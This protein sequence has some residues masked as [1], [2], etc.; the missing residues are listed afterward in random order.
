M[1]F[2]LT[3]DDRDRFLRAFTPPFT[4]SAAAQAYEELRF[5]RVLREEPGR[6]LL[7]HGTGA[8]AELTRRGDT[9]VTL[10]LHE[11]PAAEPFVR[12]YGFQPT[13]EERARVQRFLTRGARLEAAL[14]EAFPRLLGVVE[15]PADALM[16]GQRRRFS[17]GTGGILEVDVDRDG[18]IRAC[19][20]LTGGRA[21][22]VFLNHLEQKHWAVPDYPGNPV[23][24][25]S[26]EE[27]D[28]FLAVQKG[29]PLE[30]RE[31]AGRHEVLARVP[32]GRYRFVFELT[33]GA[34][35]SPCL[36]PADLV[37]FASR[38]ERELPATPADTTPRRR[39]RHRELLRMAAWG[40]R[41][42]IRF[43][44]PGEELPPLGIYHTR[45]G[46]FFRMTNPERFRPAALEA[47]AQR[48]EALAER[49]SP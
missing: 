29:E 46:E 33:P 20:W 49:W 39:V 27:A 8:V 38:V 31:V 36:D 14:S 41:E 45:A 43:V 23:R 30:R 2:E 48:L 11:G 1:K 24:V 42:A 7:Q 25:R 12:T 22:D 17:I 26:P 13:D 16:G 34:D 18:A 32:E 4:W 47:S 15:L 28:L 9:I 19:R 3:R 5:W 6:V 40:L 44:P 10:Q 21:L 37:L 35:R